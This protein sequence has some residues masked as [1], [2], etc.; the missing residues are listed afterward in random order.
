M[1]YGMRT[2]ESVLLTAQEGVGKTEVMHSILHQLLRETDENIGA[3]FLEE[4]KQ[5]LLQAIAGIHLQKPVHLPDVAVTAAETYQAVKDVV[6]LDDRL[7]LYSHFG[8]D[9][10]DSILDTVRF[11]VASRDCRRVL[12]D[13]ITMV[14][15][16]LGG[17]RRADSPGLSFNA[18]RNDGEG[19]RLHVD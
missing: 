3:I 11:L 12:L 18:A 14:V 16:G 13:H 8:S 2:G 5:R 19:I 17:K 6:R 10:P 1:T 15:S 7:H 4:P 9:D